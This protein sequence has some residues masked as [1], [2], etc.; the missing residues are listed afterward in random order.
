M[1]LLRLIAQQTFDN[2]LVVIKSFVLFV[3]KIKQSEFFA[4]KVESF[5]FEKKTF[6]K[7]WKKRLFLKKN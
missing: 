2:Q 7:L 4:A 6:L 1:F 5:D 3:E